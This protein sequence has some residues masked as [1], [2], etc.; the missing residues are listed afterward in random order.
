MTED[1]I[2]RRVEREMDKLDGRLMNG[3]LS[4]DDYNRNAANLNKVGGT[5]IQAL[6]RKGMTM[7]KLFVECKSRSVVKRRYPWAAVIAAADGGFWVFESTQ[8]FETWK[9]QK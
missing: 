6:L 5:A 3:L 8:D 2:E 4:Q 9:G 1:Q 7:R